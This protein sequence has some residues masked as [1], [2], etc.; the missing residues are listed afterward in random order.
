MYIFTMLPNVSIKSSFLNC[1]SFA[2]SVALLKLTSRNLL[3]KLSMVITNCM[4]LENNG[5]RKFQL[6]MCSCVHTCCFNF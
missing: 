6:N 2:N 1:M 3:T 5:V 4:Q